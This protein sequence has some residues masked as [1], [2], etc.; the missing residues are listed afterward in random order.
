M[1]YGIS[2]AWIDDGSNL[3]QASTGRNVV[4]GSKTQIG[5]A[6]LSIYGNAYFSNASDRII[7]IQASAI[8]VACK[9]LT[10]RGADAVSPMTTDAIGVVGSTVAVQT[11]QGA[12]ALAASGKA[13]GAGGDF[14]VTLAIGGAGD[15]VA[16]SGATGQ[17]YWRS[18]SN[19]IV[20]NFYNTSTPAGGDLANIIFWGKDDAGATVEYADIAIETGATGDGTHDGVFVIGVA[21]N[22][23]LEDGLLIG[24]DTSDSEWF[25]NLAEDSGLS[26]M[27]ATSDDSNGTGIFFIG[28][29]DGGKSHSGAGYD[30]QPI[31]IFGGF[32]TDAVSG[33]T[34]GGDGANIYAYG[35]VSGSGSGTGDDG[36][37][38]NTILAYSADEGAAIGSVAVGHATP[39]STFDIVGSQGWNVTTVNA[40]TYDIVS[41]DHILNVT[42]TDT[43][44]VTSLTLMTAE[45]VARRVLVIKDAGGNA[46]GNNIT[47]DTEAAQTIDGAG[48]AVISGDYDSITLYC[49]GTNW[50]II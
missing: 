46:S 33:D 19:E 28:G 10:I 26:L 47:V 30:G 12:S 18:G 36:T 29:A 31:E 21:A 32:G 16:D 23:S 6:K 43:A 45:T 20:Q 4:I 35:G 48:T 17:I 49:D 22:G 13:G 2:R 7:G 9:T 1:G 25:Y 3:T 37:E 15:G 27:P 44:A 8:N 24:H 39:L 50:F 34:D 5:S 42:Y 14:D 41:T 40:G 11:G 38:G